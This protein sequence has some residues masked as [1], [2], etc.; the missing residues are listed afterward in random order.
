VGLF[1]KNVKIALYKLELKPIV[2]YNF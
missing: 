1:Y 2:L